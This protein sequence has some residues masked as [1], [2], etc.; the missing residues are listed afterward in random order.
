MSNLNKQSNPFPYSEEL[1]GVYTIG[2]NGA[3]LCS[4]GTNKFIIQ[5]NLN[6]Q[7]V[8]VAGIPYCQMPNGQLYQIQ[9]QSTY[10]NSNH[11]LNQMQQQQPQYCNSNHPLNQMQQQQ[12]QYCNSNHPLN[13]MQ[14]QQQLQYCNS[15]HPLNQINEFDKINNNINRANIDKSQKIYTHQQIDRHYVTFPNGD[16]NMIEHE[17][18]KSS[19]DKNLTNSYCENNKRI[20]RSTPNQITN[21]VTNSSTCPQNLCTGPPIYYNK[22]T[23]KTYQIDYYFTHV[24]FDGVKRIMDRPY[25]GCSQYKGYKGYIVF[26]KN[27]ELYCTIHH[28]GDAI[29]TLL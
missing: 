25:E 29:T 9:Q 2:L 23:K 22:H 4:P 24:V 28:S 16:R 17:T 5:P 10:C 3:I 20:V 15:N 26:V 1:G 12:P 21:I 13:Q 11:P 19:N 18:I 27:D 14:Q 6:Y 7:I 8:T